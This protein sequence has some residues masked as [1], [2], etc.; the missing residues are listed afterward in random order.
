M[1]LNKEEV[2]KFFKLW[3]E[4]LTF[5][6]HKYELF[7]KVDVIT[8]NLEMN[9]Y[10]TLRDKLW[11]DEKLLD[12]YLLQAGV[13]H[14][15]DEIEIIQSWKRR[16][17]GDYYLIKHLKRYSVFMNAKD[18]K[19]LYG[20][21]GISDPIK[22]T[23]ADKSL[24]IALKAVFLPFAGKIIYDGVFSVYPVTIGPGIKASFHEEYMQIK[25]ESGIIT[26]L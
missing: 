11:E 20:V 19:R 6:N 23:L 13:F 4:I 25:K 17:K 1:T 16:L 7:P 14:T 10:V 2:R 12:E 21:I 8:Q 15:P 24:P 3:F 22:K 5:T 9:I 18:D 26:T